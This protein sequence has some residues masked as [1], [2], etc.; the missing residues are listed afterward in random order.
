MSQC[1]PYHF[2]W[3][4]AVVRDLPP[5]ARS[6]DPDGKCWW[7]ADDMASLLGRRVPE[8]GD[9]IA[10]ANR[11]R[12]QQEEKRRRRYEGIS[13]DIPAK[14]IDAFD[15]LT[16]TQDAPDELVAA[17]RKIYARLHH[18]D[19]AGG[20]HRLMVAKNAAADTVEAWRKAQRE[21]QRK[22]GGHAN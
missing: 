20:D 13:L 8:L 12:Q 14:V 18:P 4:L 9:Y 15:E 16:L 6:Y 17:A 2:E 3:V 5:W 11:S 22:E 21:R 7:I 10:Q 19:H 1:H